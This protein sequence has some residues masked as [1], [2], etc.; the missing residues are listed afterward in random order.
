M[1]GILM[2]FGAG[3]VY[4]SACSPSAAKSCPHLHGIRTLEGIKDK[5]QLLSE[6]SGAAEHT[7]NEEGVATARDLADNLRDAII[8]YQVGFD[9][10]NACGTVRSRC[11]L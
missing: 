9:V 2:S 7:E 1:R 10:K 4:S 3:N 8:E 5:L 6:H 11:S